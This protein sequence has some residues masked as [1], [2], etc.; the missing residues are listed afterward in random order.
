MLLL[1]DRV[2]ETINVHTDTQIALLGDAFRYVGDQS[3]AL[4]AM[5]RFRGLGE[6][7]DIAAPAVFVASADAKCITGVPLAVD[8]DFSAQ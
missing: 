8:C 7:E 5:H 2:L 1:Q 4:R 6:V 3:E